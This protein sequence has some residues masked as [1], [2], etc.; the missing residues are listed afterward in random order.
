MSET[1]RPP[2]HAGPRGR[3]AGGNPR[4]RFAELHVDYEEGEEPA[5]IATKFFVDHA[6]SVITRNNSPDLGFDGSINPYRGCEHGCAYCYARPTHEY[7]GF[8][9][10]LDFE[11]RIMVKPDAPRLLREALMK[12]GYRPVLLSMSGV[13][14][15]YQP[16]E[17]K[18]GITRACLGVL[19]EFRHPVVIV[20]KNHLVL[21]DV[22]HVSELVRHRAAGVFISLT[23]LDAKLA[24]R[25]EPRASSPAQRLDAIRRL[26]EA[27]IPVGVLVAPVIPGLNDHEMLAILDAAGAAGAC[28]ASYT[29]V[30]LP[31]AVKAVFADWLAEH[32]PER[33]EKILG[34]IRELQGATMS[35]GEFGKRLR[36]AGVWAGQFAQVFRVS[37]ARSGLAGRGMPEISAA[38]F[39][40]PATTAQ[41]E[42]A[43]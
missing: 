19:A 42:L 10:G 41:M 40:R 27:G 2:G 34:R 4:Q 20:T 37:M 21:R 3:G 16:I 7:L 26:H 38:A 29:A 31:F 33:K 12:R 1:D 36:G 25:L 43:L 35:R 9:A 28:T 17:K 32:F 22:D 23:S 15:C 5:K 13:T 39:R 8:S 6:S 18:L 11:S 24:H 14:D 30:R